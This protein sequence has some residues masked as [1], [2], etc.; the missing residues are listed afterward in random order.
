VEP[1]QRPARRAP[2]RR[3]KDARVRAQAYKSRE[4]KR[5]GIYSFEKR[6]K[7]LPA[8]LE[9]VFRGNG[10]A[11]AHWTG[12]PPGYRRTATWWVVSAVREET[13]LSRL[14][15]L[16]EAHAGSRRIGLLSPPAPSKPS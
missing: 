6:P 9:A 12:Q 7:A 16:M 5:T 13:R 4:E 2:D 8:K 1:R 15:R 14:A 3:G 10:A 11:W